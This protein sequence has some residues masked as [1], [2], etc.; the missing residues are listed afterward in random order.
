MAG[1]E[2]PDVLVLG[3][4]GILGEAWMTAVLAGLEDATGFDPRGCDAFV[5]TSAGSIVSAIL[6]AGV[7]PRERLGS[8]PEPP[9]V[10][11][12]EL[13]GPPGPLAKAL[14]AGVAAAGT[15]AAP[16]AALGLGAIEPGGAVL[17]RAAL[18]RVRPGTR[19][20]ERLG[21]ELEEAGASFDGRLTV[22]A[23]EVESGR[24]VMFGAPGSPAASLAAAVEASCAIPGVF[25]PIPLN[26]RSYVDGGVW[27]P[28]NLDRAPVRRDTRVLCL[29]PTGSLRPNL[30]TPFG[31]VGLLSRSVA[32]VEALV[33]ERKGA[34]VRIASPD[35]ASRAAMGANLMDGGPRAEV[36]AAGLAQGRALAGHLF[37]SRDRESRLR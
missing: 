7:E 13:S 28:T 17:R 30:D 14:A 33:L 10:A 22:A 6:V 2:T 19:S 5:G 1:L 37:D 25:R 15:V 12:A 18:R 4:G 31:G 23:V 26:G 35:P 34:S 16:L 20:L 32:A 27:S 9:P 11:G 8:L 24:R 21:R 29:N 3:G 36:V